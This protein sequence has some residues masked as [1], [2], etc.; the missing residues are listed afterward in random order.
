MH[1]CF[2]KSFV[3]F[4]IKCFKLV[5]KYLFFIFELFFFSLLSICHT[6]KT[7]VMNTKSLFRIV[8]STFVAA[9]L[10]FI[11]CKKES[12]AFKE[13]A[14]P[15]E[16]VKNVMMNAKLIND[17]TLAD[18]QTYT[19][20]TQP[21]IF[22][23]MTPENKTRLVKERIDFAIA[24]ETN[25][26][27]IQKLNQLKSMITVAD[28]S[29]NPDPIHAAAID[30]Y[31][32]TMI[33]WFGYEKTRML[34]R[35]WGNEGTEIAGGG[36]STKCTCSSESD[37][38]GLG[39]GPGVSCKAKADDCLKTSG[40]CGNFWKSD[41]DGKCAIGVSSTSTPFDPFNYNL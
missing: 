31:I 22:A 13:S 7:N 6:L 40:G 15:D 38:C 39:G 21:L 25:A 26:T 17:Y 34:V 10:L 30:T 33:P 32:E 29:A 24:K 41:C 27:S 16:N 5:Y 3:I 14:N 1:P 9:A 4:I 20:A 37:W 11:A 35:S 2:V 36:A 12:K 8:C 23:S 28:Y 18:M 19:F